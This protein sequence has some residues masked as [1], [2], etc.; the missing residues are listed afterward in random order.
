MN[1]IPIITIAAGAAVVVLLLLLVLL[2][3]RRRSSQNAGET[4]EGPTEGT[5]G[6]P[7]FLDEA[8]QDT[9]SGLGAVERMAEAAP[10]ESVAP[11]PGLQAAER[12]AAAPAG[13]EWGTPVLSRPIAD[14]APR[15]GI[16]GPT[17]PA[18]PDAESE[19]VVLPAAPGSV[20]EPSVSGEDASLGVTERDS[21]AQQVS[22]GEAVT[23]SAVP[24]IPEAAMGVH[25]MVPLSDVLVTTST[26]LVNLDDPRVRRMLTDLINL[27]V[28]QSVQFRQ[29][30]QSVDAIMQLTEAE[31]ISRALGLHESTHRIH[32]MIEDLQRDA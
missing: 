30:G 24:P 9:L 2:M 28:D 20:V 29:A 21:N 26:K 31:R 1:G 17:V 13:L 4:A 7:S 32:E 27:E 23:S 6:M 15:N 10:H 3:L 19:T 18:L 8:P 12:P 14:S 16:P 22:P 11:E 5:P 25:R